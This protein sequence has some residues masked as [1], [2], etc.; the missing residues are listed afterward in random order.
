MQ[1]EVAPEQPAQHVGEL[2]QGGVVDGGLA[3]A[4]VVHQQV[5]DRTVFDGV[6]VDQL[7]AAQLALGPQ[8]PPGRGSLEDP[9]SPQQLVEVRAGGVAAA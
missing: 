1:L 6:A 9:R 7:L 3:F 5:P 4:Q 8:R 2:V